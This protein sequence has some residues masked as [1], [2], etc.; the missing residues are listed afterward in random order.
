MLGIGFAAG[1]K[2]GLLLTLALTGE[3]LSLGLAASSEL[4]Q[5]EMTCP[6]AMATISG[7]ALLFIVSAAG[8]APL[9]HNL[10]RKVSETVLAFGVAALL[11]FVT[12]ELLVEAH[13][14]KGTPPLAAMFFGGFLLFLLLGMLT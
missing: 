11:F 10:P 8:G 7:L 14:E 12:E 6:R 2:E 5:A 13:E 1:A 3:L 4:R 9:L